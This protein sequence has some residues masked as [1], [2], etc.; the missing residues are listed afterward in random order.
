MM[1]RSAGGS[2]TSRNWFASLSFKPNT[3]TQQIE[4]GKILKDMLHK[5]D[6]ISF[7]VRYKCCDIFLQC[8]FIFFDRIYFLNCKAVLANHH[9]NRSNRKCKSPAN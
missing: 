6:L 1:G 9:F 4:L 2:Q 7:N 8:L 5:K 3:Y